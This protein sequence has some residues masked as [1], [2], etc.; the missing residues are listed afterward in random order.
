MAGALGPLNEDFFSR[1]RVSRAVSA[2]AVTWSRRGLAFGLALAP[3]LVVWLVVFAD[4]AGVGGQATSRQS[5]A[6]MFARFVSATATVATIAVAVAS[7]TLGRELRGVAGQAE[8]H[9]ANEGFRD[10]VREMGGRDVVPMQ[11]GPFLAELQSILAEAAER[12]RGAASSEAAALRHE[13]VTLDELLDDIAQRSRL[14]AR[15]LEGTRRPHEVLLASLDAETEVTHHLVRRFL[16]D[17]RVEGPLRDELHRI[18]RLLREAGIGAGYAKTLNFQWGLSRMSSMVLVATLP[19]LLASVGMVLFYAEPSGV[20]AWT[21]PL[22]GG[23]LAFSLFLA[24]LPTT[25]FVSYLLRFVFVNARTL[26]TA[27][28]VLGP[29]LRDERAPTGRRRGARA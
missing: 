2:V 12:A 3:A 24:L 19:A 1:A 16:R 25:A 21:R 28:F 7:L 5:V 26:P 23:V 8:H 6:E 14:H 17:G 20:G 22:A 15:R 13:G 11:L 9:D 10:R 27:D 4:P 29:E 18:E